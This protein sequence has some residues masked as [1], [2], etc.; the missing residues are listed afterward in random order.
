MGQ[1]DI[2]GREMQEVR[3]R[4]DDARALREAIAFAERTDTLP[5]CEHGS[6]LRDG[7][8]ERLQPPCGCRL[9]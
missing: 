9:P 8:G 7:A 4:I 6:C 5:R 3:A 1:R 2:G